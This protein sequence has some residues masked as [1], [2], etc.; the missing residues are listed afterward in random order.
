LIDGRRQLLGAVSKRSAARPI[1][2]DKIRVAE[3]ADREARSASR[4]DQRL[5]PAKRQKTAARPGLRAFA[6][7]LRPAACRRFL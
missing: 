7:H 4:P 3:A 2:A 1:D 6:L 5:Q